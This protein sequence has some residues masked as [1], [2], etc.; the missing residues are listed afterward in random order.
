MAIAQAMDPGKFQEFKEMSES[1][2][3]LLE[4]DLGLFRDPFIA[5]VEMNDGFVYRDRGFLKI[6]WTDDEE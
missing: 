5:Q 4:S 6:F 2:E 3:G 1:E